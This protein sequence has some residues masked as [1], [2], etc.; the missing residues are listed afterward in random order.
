MKIETIKGFRDYSGEE[1]RKRSEIRRIIVETFERYGFEPAET[2]VIESEEFVKGDN[3]EDE[4]VSDI[5]RLK[6]KGERN[7]ALRYEFTFQLKRL[8]KNKKLPYKRYQIGPVFRDEPVSSERGRQFIQCDIDTVGSTVKDEAEILAAFNEL[9]KQLG[10]KPMI[11]V[12]NRKLLNEVL[13]Y[14]KIDKKDRENVLREI[15]K[16]DKLP[17]KQVIKNLDKY[18]AGNL[19]PEFKKGSKFFSQFKSYKEVLEL[20]NICKDYG[21]EAIFLPTVVRGLSYYDGSVFEIKAKGLKSSIAGGGSYTFNKTPSTGI[22]FSIERLSTVAKL[23]KESERMLIISL[24]EDKEA[25]KIAQALRRNKKNVSIFY[26]KPS[27]ALQYANSYG[28]TKA[29][30]V[31]KQEVKKR[32]FK[33]KDLKTGGQSRLEL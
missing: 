17:E 19:I 20:V 13:D 33:V 6:D 4:A 10:I 8:M 1:A 16:Y 29:I 23:T 30:F 9:F 15:D 7:L 25:I 14:A 26:G 32:E 21:V 27:K 3:K 24:N 22:S 11:L 2:P 5:Y 12:N 28:F 18:G 31:G